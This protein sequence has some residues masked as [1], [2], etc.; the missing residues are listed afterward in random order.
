M[1]KGMITTARGEVLNM[2]ELIARS[3]A[4]IGRKAEKSTRE[5]P[6]QPRS[7]QPQT[8]VRGFVPQRGTTETPQADVADAPAHAT[9][10]TKSGG[11][12]KS[13]ADMTGVKVKPTARAKALR[14]KAEDGVNVADEVLGDLL[15]EM[16]ASSG[17]V[18]QAEATER[19][20]RQKE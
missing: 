1:A 11:D 18:A 9:A 14:A 6:Y 7:V 4:P 13:L 12:T 8:R 19:A 2:D 5:A 10:A 20:D 17:K 16:Q 15:N 3:Q